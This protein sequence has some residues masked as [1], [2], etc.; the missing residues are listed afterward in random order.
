MEHHKR[1]QRNYFFEVNLG[2]NEHDQLITTKVFLIIVGYVVIIHLISDNQNVD[3]S[4]Q[5]MD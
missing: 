5:F 2:Y 4:K 1:L 3:R